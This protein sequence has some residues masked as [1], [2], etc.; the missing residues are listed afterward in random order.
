MH[1]KEIDGNFFL[2]R[3][4]VLKS[5]LY[6]LLREVPLVSKVLPAPQ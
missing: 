5:D 3:F 2:L 6:K 1:D 4:V